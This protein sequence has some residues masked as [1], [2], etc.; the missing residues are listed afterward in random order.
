MPGNLNRVRKRLKT[1]GLKVLGCWNTEGSFRYDRFGPG[2]TFRV[3]P[4]RFSGFSHSA[5]SGLAGPSGVEVMGGNEEKSP[6][7]FWREGHGPKPASPGQSRSGGVRKGFPAVW[8]EGFL[9]DS[10]T[11]VEKGGC[12][13]GRAGCVY[14]RERSPGI[15]MGSYTGIIRE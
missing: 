15:D 7:A 3:E 14:S 4:A 13:E 10:Q 9:L 2:S 6:H 12:V 8:I 5:S 11:R 1:N